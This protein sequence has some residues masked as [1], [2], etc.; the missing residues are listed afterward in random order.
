MN[1]MKVDKK[2]LSIFL[3]LLIASVFAIAPVSAKKP[4]SDGVQ[5]LQVSI[6]GTDLV[7]LEGDGEEND[8]LL[9]G[10]VDVLTGQSG[11][12]QVTL[13]LSL[14]YLG[15]DPENPIERKTKFDTTLRK[16]ISVYCEGGSWSESD[17]TFEI[18]NKL[19]WYR[20]TVTAK[21]GGISAES[22]PFEFDPP[23]GSRGPVHR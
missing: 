21:C 6:T 1:T 3:I 22:D 9:H 16:T 4:S 14:K 11:T 2:I 10:K 7:D 20:A 12:Y 15:T 23:G 17:F 5:G 13:T 19:G 18:Y 8:V